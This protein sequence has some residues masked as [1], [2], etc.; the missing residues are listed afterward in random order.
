[1]ER[2]FNAD[3]IAATLPQ[4][5]ILT[6][7]NTLIFALYG[8]LDRLAF[9]NDSRI[10]LLIRYS[11]IVPAGLITLILLFIPAFIRFR[12]LI[13][14]A[15]VTLLGC[16]I[17][18]ITY[19]APHPSHEYY[20]VGILTVFIFVIYAVSKL[21]LRFS[22]AAGCTIVAV[23]HALFLLTGRITSELLIHDSVILNVGNTAGIIAA[24]SIEAFTR[25]E[26]LKRRELDEEREKIS[27]LNRKLEQRVSQR[28][29]Q[30]SQANIELDY[31]AY[32]DSLTGMGNRQFM[33]KEVKQFIKDARAGNTSFALVIVD[34]DRFSQ[35]ND[36]LGNHNAD[37]VLRIVARRL[38]QA[39]RAVDL[40]VRLGSDEFIFVLPRVS[41]SGVVQAILERV[42]ENVGRPIEVGEH[43]IEVTL[44]CGAS[45][46]PQDAGSYEELLRCANSAVSDAKSAGPDQLRFFTPELGK[47]ISYRTRIERL[48]SGAVTR[49]EFSLVYQRKVNTKTGET[50]GVEALIRWNSAELG[51]VS[52][53]VFIPIAEESGAIRAVDDWVLRNACRETRELFAS[54]AKTNS[55]P[56]L[57]VNV[58]ANHFCDGAFADRTAQ[59]LTEVEF[60]PEWMQF[61]VTESGMMYEPAGARENIRRLRDIGAAIS[62]DDFGTGYSSLAYLS[63]FPIDELKIDRS[64]VVNLETSSED[65]AIIQSI[66]AL[67]YGLG[68]R[69]VAEG[70]ETESQRR[71]LNAFGCHIVQG[72]LYSRPEPIEAL[73]I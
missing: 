48:L 22:A 17:V 58:S 7:I 19:I 9:G 4:P 12:N 66:I 23:Y 65:Q 16:F 61:E 67:G 41:D 50:E 14:T 20:S 68:S 18:M 29:S 10:L 26:F 44:G 36:S 25:R 42:S 39:L 5:R 63:R 38:F 30:L 8:L 2:E 33:E 60:P 15:F 56:R 1:M 28:N 11:V 64:F 73:H 27:T 45:M 34:I 51:N 69:V 54:A 6:G 62:I 35:I 40:F 52:P 49:G 31:L 70:V 46:F 37:E 59:I 72:Y 3:F 47:K 71:L 53:A 32:H 57:S 24:Y 55:V 21:P 13:Y 43:T